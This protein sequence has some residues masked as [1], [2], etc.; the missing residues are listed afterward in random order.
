MTDPDVLPSEDLSRVFVVVI[1]SFSLC[2]S[3]CRLKQFVLPKTFMEQAAQL[4]WRS[5]PSSISLWEKRQECWRDQ[6]LQ[7]ASEAHA[8][9]TTNLKWLSEWTAI[10][11]LRFGK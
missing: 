6:F 7:I 10:W 5:D 8:S 9:A 2:L 1:F 11:T 4:Q 3:I